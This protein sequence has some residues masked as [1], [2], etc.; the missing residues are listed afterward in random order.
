MF[1]YIPYDNATQ[2]EIYTSH[3]AVRRLSTVAHIRL[4]IHVGHTHIWIT[5]TA[6]EKAP[7]ACPTYRT[8]YSIKLD[9]TESVRTYLRSRVL[10]TAPCSEVV[11]RFPR[12]PG[13][14]QPVSSLLRGSL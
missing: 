7:R 10:E 4:V 3:V 9:H 1:M 12:N 14:S 6:C 13:R 8:R 2:Y 11:S 5:P